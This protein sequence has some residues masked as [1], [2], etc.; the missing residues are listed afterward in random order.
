VCPAYRKADGRLAAS[1]FHI[2]DQEI[3]MK[4]KFYL[5]IC[6]GLIQISC[7]VT[8]YGEE[9]RRGTLITSQINTNW[10][11]LVWSKTAEEIITCGND[12]INAININTKE[13]RNLQG[14]S[15]FAI[16]L[17]DDGGT[18]YYLQGDAIQGGVEPLYSISLD[19][20]NK[21]LLIDE[22]Y[23]DCFCISPLGLYIAYTGLEEESVLIYNTENQSIRSLCNGIPKVFSPDGK[24]LICATFMG[25]NPEYFIIDIETESVTPLSLVSLGIDENYGSY[26]VTFRWLETGIYVLYSLGEPELFYVHNYTTD[27]NIFSW[28]VN[29]GGLFLNWTDDAEKIAYWRSKASSNT[30]NNTLYVIDLN[31]GK[32]RDVVFAK[33]QVVCNIAFSPDKKHIAYVLGSSI[34]M[35]NI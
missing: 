15:T 33:D 27:N 20:Q 22:V 19:G 5:M 18:I 10:L 35:T 16:R 21:R 4:R 32:V 3:R 8:E 14:N 23:V 7:G 25:A 12:G 6:L 34:Y 2:K 31:L 26:I 29:D 17:S 1:I 11:N 28:K 30:F 13:I 24:K 9:E